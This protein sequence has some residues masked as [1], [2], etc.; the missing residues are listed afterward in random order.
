ML[1]YN[2]SVEKKNLIVVAFLKNYKIGYEFTSWPNHIT[3]VPYFFTANLDKFIQNIEEP[4]LNLGTISCEI[5]E[6]IEIG[7]NHGVPASFVKSSEV[8]SLFSIVS[9]EAFLHDSAIKDKLICREFTPHITHKEK[10]YPKEGEKFEI[11]E[12]YVVQK[13]SQNTKEKKIIGKIIL[14]L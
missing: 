10:P 13:I 14:N 8:R 6:I 2:Q 1:L 3:I 7:H 4:C 11:K 5:G 12:I 9:R